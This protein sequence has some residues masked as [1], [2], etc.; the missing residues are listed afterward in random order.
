MRVVS[1]LRMLMV[2]IMLG[3]L[4]MILQLLLR[5]EAEGSGGSVKVVIERRAYS[6]QNLLLKLLLHRHGLHAHD[7]F[8]RGGRHHQGIIPIVWVLKVLVLVES[9]GVPAMNNVVFYAH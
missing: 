5:G 8:L 3:L 9:S 4:I 2:L 6:I 7:G 1:V